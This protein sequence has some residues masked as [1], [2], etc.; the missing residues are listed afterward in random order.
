MAIGKEIVRMDRRKEMEKSLP[1]QK[2][3][4]MTRVLADQARSTRNAAWT[5]SYETDRLTLSA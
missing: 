2:A 1:K 5:R 3:G 4:A